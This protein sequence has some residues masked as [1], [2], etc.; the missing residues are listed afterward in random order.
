MHTKVANK[1]NRFL[2]SFLFRMVQIN[3]PAF[4]ISLINFIF[5]VQKDVLLPLEELNDLSSIA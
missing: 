2:N 1:Q 4:G 3:I 5:D